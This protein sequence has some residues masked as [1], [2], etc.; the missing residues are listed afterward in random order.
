MVDFSQHSRTLANILQDRGD[1]LARKELSKYGALAHGVQGVGNAL[2]D[3][4]TQKGE[5]KSQE[6]RARAQQELLTRFT[7]SPSPE[8]LAPLIAFDPQ[9]AG[10]ALQSHRAFQDKPEKLTEL[11]R[12]LAAPPEGQEEILD[13]RRRMSEAGREPESPT[14][15]EEFLE[16]SPEKQEQVLEVIRR[17]TAARRS[18]PAAPKEKAKKD[19][20]PMARQILKDQEAAVTPQAIDLL[21][22][23]LE[24]LAG[25]SGR[26]LDTGAARSGE[27]DIGRFNAG[28]PSPTGEPAPAE[29]LTEDAL[30][31]LKALGLQ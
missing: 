6:G 26:D 17:L 8:T 12:F 2:G 24:R 10:L 13:A 18:P 16:F 28:Q 21:A 19:Y 15:V 22:R 23:E 27:L 3:W 20:R 4:L 30:A 11:Q 14:E 25:L 5:R 29:E 9:V 7:E 1:I 31:T